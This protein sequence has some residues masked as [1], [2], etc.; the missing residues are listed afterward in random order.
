MKVG[1]SADV[2]HTHTTSY[3]SETTRDETKTVVEGTGLA[4]VGLDW[5]YFAIYFG[6]ATNLSSDTTVLP[7]GSLRLGRSDVFAFRLSFADSL[8]MRLALLSAELEGQYRSYFRAALGLRA[9][10]SAA[11][12]LPGLRIEFPYGKAHWLG[13]LG[14]V[15]YSEGAPAW[16]LQ[17]RATFQL[18][19]PPSAVKQSTDGANRD[20]R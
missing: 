19:A 3:D 10:L 6:A 15:G 12:V 7:S 1:G 11:N 2:V 18:Y 17:L 14:A 8:P 13:V 5:R 9:D 4:Q 20:E 16:Q